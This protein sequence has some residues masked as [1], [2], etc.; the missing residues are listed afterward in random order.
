[1][2][3]W[4]GLLDQAKP[5]SWNHSFF[6]AG[7][8]TRIGRVQ[9]GSTVCDVDPVAIKQHRSIGLSVASMTW[10]GLIINLIDTPGYADFVADLRAGLRAAD[11]ALFVIGAVDGVD[12]ATQQLWDEC[13]SV[14]LPRAIVVTKL[15]RDRADF[16][17]TVA[18]CRRVFAGGGGVLPCTYRFT[19][20]TAPRSVSSIC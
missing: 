10:Q 16:D 1:M 19:R 13:D 20:T 8:T 4:S 12:A 3:C 15:D 2:W 17:E 18:V 9:D 7:A 11:A 5:H 14:G 6:A